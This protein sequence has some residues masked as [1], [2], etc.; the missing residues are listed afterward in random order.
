MKEILLTTTSPKEFIETIKKYTKKI[1]KKL[2]PDEYIDEMIDIF[3]N[4]KI[5]FHNGFV[6]HFIIDMLKSCNTPYYKADELANYLLS[7]YDS[8]RPEIM[9]PWNIVDEKYWIISL[10]PRLIGKRSYDFLIDVLHNE[11]DMELKY[12]SMKMLATVSKQTFDR[13]IPKVYHYHEPNCIIRYDEIEQWIADGCPDGEGYP[14]P[15][16][17]DALETPVTD[18]EQVAA[19]LNTK[20]K[21]KQDNDDY[22]S[23]T[24]FLVVANKEKV[25]YL[26]EKYQLGGNYLE[27]LTRF[28]PC[29]VLIE[30]GMYEVNLYGVDVLEEKQIGYSVS[31]DGKSFEDWPSSYLVIADRMADPYCIDLRKENSK[32]YI[33][34]HGEGEWKFRK[35]YNSFEDFL[36][37][38]AK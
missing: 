5:H 16:L 13:N 22:S 24:N 36:L 11:N 33:A 14:S 31:N 18:L 34:N 9:N 27:F 37:Y 29:N 3:K 30:K 32:V 25:N 15:N 6:L 19:K 38:L 12:M 35:A 28:S 21:P 2:T 17:D 1:S 4:N 26:Q 10:V 7:H 23:Y 8:E 20:L